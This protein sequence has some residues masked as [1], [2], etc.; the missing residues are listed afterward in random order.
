MIAGRGAVARDVTRRQAKRAGGDDER[1][2]EVGGR[3]TLC[4]EGFRHAERRGIGPPGATPVQCAVEQEQALDRILFAATGIGGVVHGSVE[5]LP[6]LVSTSPQ[7]VSSISSTGPSTYSF[8][9]RLPKPSRPKRS[10]ASQSTCTSQ[11][12]TVWSSLSSGVTRSG[13]TRRLRGRAKR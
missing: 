7:F 8:V 3:G 11:S 10:L 9:V 1:K 2:S 12:V 6:S 13:W 5:P 4:V